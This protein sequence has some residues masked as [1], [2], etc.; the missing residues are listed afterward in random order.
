MLLHVF[1]HELGHHFDKIH[2]K[3]IGSTK[4]EDYAERF[5]TNRFAQLFPAYVCVFGN[6]A[7]GD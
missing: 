1:M 6:P 5:A 4:G 7:R 3:H 2:Q